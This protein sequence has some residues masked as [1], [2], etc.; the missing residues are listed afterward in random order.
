[1]FEKSK[2]DIASL[3]DLMS[4]V[5]VNGGVSPRVMDFPHFCLARVCFCTGELDKFNKGF[6]SCET[7][8]WR[9]FVGH[10]RVGKYMMI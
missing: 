4:H 10:C 1:M 6:Y 2:A 8:V 5:C 7:N 9:R 3:V